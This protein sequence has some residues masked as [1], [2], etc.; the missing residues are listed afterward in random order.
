MCAAFRLPPKHH[1]VTAP[2]THAA[3]AV[4]LTSG[5]KKRVEKTDRAY[6]KED[7]VNG[8]LDPQISGGWGQPLKGDYPQR[9]TSIYH[10]LDDHEIYESGT[11]GSG[12]ELGAQSKDILFTV[13]Q[14]LKRLQN[15][16]PRELAKFLNERYLHDVLWEVTGYSENTFK[17]LNKEVHH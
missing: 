8:K 4:T 9:G 16:K 11:A 13:Y 2:Q 15:K 7:V 3:K 10:G 5:G 14:N 6:P 12:N 17:N 1:D